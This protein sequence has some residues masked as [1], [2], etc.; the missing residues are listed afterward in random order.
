ME[1]YLI[2]HGESFRSA[3]EYY[4]EAK[5]AMDPPLTENG[6][7]QARKLAAGLAKTEIDIIYTSD[8]KR[9]VETA[10]I[11]DDKTACGVITDTLFREIDMG[12][13]HIRSW[14]EYPEIYGRWKQHKEDIPYP[15]GESGTDV[16]N[17]CNR[18]IDNILNKSYTRAAIVCHGGT[19]RSVICGLLDIPQQKRFYFGLPPENCSVNIIK[20]HNNEFY[21]HTFNDI[22]YI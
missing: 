16:W 14:S 6:I 17:R 3:P 21:L 22:S 8:L 15:N 19:I 11:I 1:L 5:K 9:A 4:D 7:M 13:I 10:K 12:D 18:G 2:R 20:L